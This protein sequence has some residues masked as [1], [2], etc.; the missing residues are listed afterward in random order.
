MSSFLWFTGCILSG[1]QSLILGRP[2]RVEDRTL[3][4]QRSIYL[5]ASGT[6]KKGHH[7]VMVSIFTNKERQSSVI[8]G[9]CKVNTWVKTF[10][11]CFMYVWYLAL[12]F[13]I[14]KDF[15]FSYSLDLS[16]S[17]PGPVPLYLLSA[18][19]TLPMHHKTTYN[20]IKWLSY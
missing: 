19:A 14:F 9:E 5:G 7:E 17:F 10:S 18:L 3:P 20:E 2:G 15:L 1:E 6:H 11:S 13:K 8:M 16:H 4:A 12:K